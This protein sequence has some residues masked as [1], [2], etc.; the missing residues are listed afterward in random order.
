MSMQ[1]SVQVPIQLMS[2]ARNKY[3]TV[4]S[5]GAGAQALSL[6]PPLG[7]AYLILGAYG[8]HG[9]G[10]A[11]VCNW[12]FVDPLLTQN[13]Y[14]DTSIAANVQ[15]PIYANATPLVLIHGPILATYRQ[16]PVWT[17]VATGAG[18]NSYV[19]ALVYEFFF[20]ETL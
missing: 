5:G 4:A 15:W 1:N 11:R 3:L 14:A 7:S 18:E 8:Y 10:G 6:Q 12:S 20:G 19:K 9:A 16:Y 13:L 2:R 17:E